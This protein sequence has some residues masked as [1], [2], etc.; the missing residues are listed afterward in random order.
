MVKNEINVT[1]N[2]HFALVYLLGELD[3]SL[4]CQRNDNRLYANPWISEV[5]GVGWGVLLY[6]DFA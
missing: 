1:N 4:Y 3:Y 2:C 5:S 6:K